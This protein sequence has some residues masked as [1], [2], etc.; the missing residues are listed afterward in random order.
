MPCICC[1]FESSSLLWYALF[2]QLSVSSFIATVAVLSW[3]AIMLGVVVSTQIYQKVKILF[4]L[5]SSVFEYRVC[6]VLSCRAPTGSS[7]HESQELWG[8]QLFHCFRKPVAAGYSKYRWYLRRIWRVI[9]IIFSW[10]VGL[11]WRRMR[12]NGSSSSS[13]ETVTLRR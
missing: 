7:G 3:Y 13:G 12:T 10:V 5:H 9:F 2:V 1:L 6:A 4:R 11:A 8:R